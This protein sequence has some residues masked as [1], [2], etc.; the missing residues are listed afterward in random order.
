MSFRG[1]VS[2]QISHEPQLLR[3]VVEGD[4][5]Q[6]FNMLVVERIENHLSALPLL[7]EPQC[8]EQPHLMRNC[9]LR[10]A[11][12]RRNVDH[13]ELLFAQGENNF[14]PRLIAEDLERLGQADD[15]LHISHG[16]PG[17]ADGL[18]MVVRWHRFPLND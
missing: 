11:K 12:D 2:S 3:R 15:G 14:E 16:F 17:C 1:Q 4:P 18:L 10:D 9:R 8:L 6:V 7:D 13:A 5:N